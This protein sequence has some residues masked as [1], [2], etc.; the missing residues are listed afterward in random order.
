MKGKKTVIF[1]FVGNMHLSFSGKECRGSC[2]IQK[3]FCESTEWKSQ[4]L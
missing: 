4:L 1:F 3:L 2:E